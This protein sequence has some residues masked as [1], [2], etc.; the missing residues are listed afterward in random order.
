MEALFQKYW[1]LAASIVLICTMALGC[2]APKPE[3]LEGVARIKISS[4][5][6]SDGETIPEEYTK[7][8]ADVSPEL[9]VQDI[10][11]ETKSLAIIMDDPDAPSR[12]FTHWLIWNIPA[13][14]TVIP[15]GIEKAE[16]V[17][18]IA[19]QGKNDFGEIGYG[20]PKPPP[21]PSHT[22]RF[23]VFALDTVLELK[24]GANR[25]QLEKAM[26]GHIIGTGVLKGKF[27]R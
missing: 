12:V 17:L 16:V 21:G 25:D 24:S 23:R 10:P 8:G 2:A 19:R 11:E 20:G 4:H 7:Y 26:E 22:Y 6:F 18:G 3:E 9:A 5:A 1:K 14:K 27:G 13:D 15:E